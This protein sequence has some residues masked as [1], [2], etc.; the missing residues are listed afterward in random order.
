MTSTQ[1]AILRN[2][3]QQLELRTLERAKRRMQQSKP[4]SPRKVRA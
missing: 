2:I 3:E 4:R 1:R